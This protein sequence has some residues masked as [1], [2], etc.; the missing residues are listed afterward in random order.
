MV[1][2]SGCLTKT[3]TESS[4]LHVVAAT[5]KVSGYYQIYFSEVIEE[6]NILS[7]KFRISSKNIQS[8]K[9]NCAI[10]KKFIDGAERIENFESSISQDSTQ[11]INIET[12][13]LKTAILSC[14][15]SQQRG[16]S[17]VIYPI[18]DTSSKIIKN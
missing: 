11:Q 2:L 4:T 12:D 7:S 3:K 8:N 1:F 17:K 14:K 15:D 5:K 18:S 16:V 9:L 10:T 13:D 6:N